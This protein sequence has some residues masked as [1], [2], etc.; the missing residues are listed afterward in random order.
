MKGKVIIV[1][2]PGLTS[3]YL[4]TPYSLTIIWKG[5]VKSLT[6]RYV[7][8]FVLSSSSKSLRTAVNLFGFLDDILLIAS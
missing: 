2:N 5:I 1:N 6:F 8:G 3:L 4:G 7:G